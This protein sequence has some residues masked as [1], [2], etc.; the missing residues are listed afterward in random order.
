MDTAVVI[1]AAGKG[2]RMRSN[3]P[4]VMH[5]IG[6]FPMLSHCIKTAQQINPWKI[7]TVL[8]HGRT[9]VMQFLQETK[10]IN[11]VCNTGRTTRYG[12]CSQDSY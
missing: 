3:R 7:I 8:G 12:S 1:L 2:T 10:K 11:R 9:E 4:K 6:N 5:E